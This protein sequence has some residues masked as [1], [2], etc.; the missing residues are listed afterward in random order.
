MD[1][2]QSR[3]SRLKLVKDQLLQN[4]KVDVKLTLD[5]D[6]TRLETDWGSVEDVA[7]GSLD[8]LW[9]EHSTWINMMLGKMNYILTR[10]QDILEK[11]QNFVASYPLNELMTCDAEDLLKQLQDILT[12]YD[13]RK[14][15]CMY[16]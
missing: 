10:G 6:M 12:T 16:I 3:M 4:P 14:C 7:R 15:T 1:D 2:F 8:T 13:V 5:D 11:Q 9:A